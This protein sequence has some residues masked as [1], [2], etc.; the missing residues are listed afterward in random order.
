MT[1]ELFLSPS[2]PLTANNYGISCYYISHSIGSQWY[3][4]SLLKRKREILVVFDVLVFEPV[5][6]ISYKFKM[7]NM[8]HYF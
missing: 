1:F 2:L 5:G 6:Y 4:L 7:T 8:L 3:I